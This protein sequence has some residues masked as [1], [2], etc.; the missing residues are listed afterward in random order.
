MS[1]LACLV[2][3]IVVMICV[4]SLIQAQHMGGRPPQEVRDATDYVKAQEEVARIEKEL[5]ELEE[6]RTQGA[7]DSTQVMQENRELDERIARLRMQA[8]AAKAGE[9]TSGTKQPEGTPHRRPV[10]LFV[11]L[12]GCLVACV[13][14]CAE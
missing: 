13:S 7:A 10:C 6:Q 5:G 3:T 12:V 1:I 14:V 8:E 9:Q 4:L 11:S 2:G